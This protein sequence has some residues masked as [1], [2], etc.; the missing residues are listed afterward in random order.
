MVKTC[1]FI[2]GTNAVGKSTLAWAII[3]HFGGIRN[4]DDGITYLN[5]GN[6]SMAGRYI[7]PPYGGVDR[8]NGTKRLPE[9][10][11]RGLTKTDT[12]I[13]EGSY[14]D[15][16][17]YNLVAAMFKA[18]RYLVVNLYAERRVI[19]QRLLERSNGM[20]GDGKRDFNKIFDK[21]IRSI[22]AARKR[23]SVGV[24]VLQIDT[25]QTPVEKELQIILKEIQ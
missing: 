3:Q 16:F 11:E 18:Q 19:L 21:Q 13:C 15:T 5:D 1:V 24:K 2:T 12:I 8:L 4:V 20:R 6:V 25:E 22:R 10:V 14:L 17:G 7:K 9:I 23:Q